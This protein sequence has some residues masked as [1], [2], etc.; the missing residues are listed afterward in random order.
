MALVASLA[1]GSFTS[2]LGLASG[3]CLY[4]VL[5]TVPSAKRFLMLGVATL[6]ALGFA[7]AANA[8]NEPLPERP[9]GESALD[10]SL[11]VRHLIIKRSW[12]TAAT[13][14]AFGWGRG[15]N[16]REMVSLE[17][18][19]NAYLLIAIERGWVALGLW[20][21]LPLCLAAMVSRT[22]RRV[23]TR[24][25]SRSILAGFCASIGTMVA[26]F[27][28]WLGLPYSSLL[29]VMLALTVNTA[30]AAAPVRQGGRRSPPP[31]A[32]HGSRSGGR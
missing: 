15:V 10:R 32:T 17:S 27:T 21:A 11:W 12:Q 19:D 25:M 20:L 6:I 16:I 31:G 7:Y 3:L 13:A 2:F 1:A 24:Y 28:V 5:S 30:E 26:L 22:L 8:V 14:G 4:L 29:M 23:R 18:L 9:V